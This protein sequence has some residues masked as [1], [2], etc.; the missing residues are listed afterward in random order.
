MSVFIYIYIHYLYAHAHCCRYVN[1]ISY[2]AIN[3]KKE[4]KRYNNRG[5]KYNWSLIEY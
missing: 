2:D 3:T 1:D 4:K 5:K